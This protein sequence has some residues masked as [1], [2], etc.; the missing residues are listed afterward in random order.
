[1]PSDSSFRSWDG[2]GDQ[3]QTAPLFARELS[4]TLSLS[5]HHILLL[6]RYLDHQQTRRSQ[7]AEVRKTSRRTTSTPRPTPPPPPPPSTTTLPSQLL[8]RP[9]RPTTPPPPPAGAR[10]SCQTPWPA[11]GRR[12]RLPKTSPKRGRSGMQ[13]TL[14]HVLFLF[15]CLSFTHLNLWLRISDFINDLC[16][17]RSRNMIETPVR[18]QRRGPGGRRARAATATAATSVQDGFFGGG[19]GGGGFSW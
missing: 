6:L 8:H 14:Y 16:G 13:L 3:K 10:A 1:M 7:I 9:R 5:L 2:R 17:G 18:S 4:S 19:G 12:G 15:P 11:S